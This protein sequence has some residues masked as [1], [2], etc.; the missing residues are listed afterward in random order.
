MTRVLYIKQGERKTFAIVDAGMN[1]LIR[2]ALYD[3][4][5]EIVRVNEAAPDARAPALRRGG[6]G[7]RNIGHL[8]RRTA[9][10]RN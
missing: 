1:D 4:H 3:S 9:I 8:R 7:V 6:S 2:P 10:C 5:H